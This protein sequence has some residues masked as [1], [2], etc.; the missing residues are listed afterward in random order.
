MAKQS[1]NSSNGRDTWQNT[2]RIKGPVQCKP[3]LHEPRYNQWVQGQG[4]E[5]EGVY[6][7]AVLKTLSESDYTISVNMPVD[8]HEKGTKGDRYHGDRIYEYA[9]LSFDIKFSLGMQR[10]FDFREGYPA[11]FHGQGMGVGLWPVTPGNH[12]S[13]SVENLQ[14]SDGTKLN[15]LLKY[16]PGGVRVSSTCGSYP[17][18][19]PGGVELPYPNET[20]F[21]D[22]KR[23][24]AKI[25]FLDNTSFRW[26][27][28]ESKKVISDGTTITLESLDGTSKTYTASPNPSPGS[29]EFNNS[30]TTQDLVISLRDAINSSTG[31]DGKLIAEKIDY[32]HVDIHYLRIYQKDVSRDEGNLGNTEILVS[33]NSITP[34]PSV[35][36]GNPLIPD[37][38]AN[39]VSGIGISENFLPS[40]RPFFGHKNPTGSFE[41]GELSDW[42]EDG[43]LTRWPTAPTD[44]YQGWRITGPWYTRLT[45][46]EH[47]PRTTGRMKSI[48]FNSYDFRHEMFPSWYHSEF[49]A[50][51]TTNPTIVIFGK[52]KSIHGQTNQ[53]G[54]PF[55]QNFAFRM[56]FIIQH[57]S[58][59]LGSAFRMGYDDF[60][61]GRPERVSSNRTI[62]RMP[63]LPVNLT[64]GHACYARMLSK[65]GFYGDESNLFKD[66]P[67]YGE[68]EIYR[69]FAPFYSTNNTMGSN[70]STA[71]P[72]RSFMSDHWG[73]DVSFPEQ[74]IIPASEL[75]IET[76][77]N[78]MV[79]TGH[80][81]PRWM[82]RVESEVVVIRNGE[83]VNPAF[84]DIYQ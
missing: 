2:I 84:Y 71:N 14:L 17:Y 13:V 54:S 62:I 69:S 32:Y 72:Y 58:A 65:G 41:G 56:D 3:G 6:N 51:M 82:K 19:T 36:Y 5:A 11:R 68:G 57:T 10:G 9:T 80:E 73:D 43:V 49:N 18:T 63:E 34:P 20:S 75:D 27:D 28:E 52:K 33:G 24:I 38:N 53:D 4:E 25:Y 48:Y 76:L 78:N 37:S 1:L 7:S 42:D 35:P 46:E 16:R 50:L 55:F 31:H 21:P 74:I 83:M 81:R 22:D 67:T 47:R 30:G 61:Q 66:G 29:T 44:S 70:S 15:S 60:Q 23:A 26:P 45:A 8:Y 77:E 79:G 12:V 39:F 40:G 59:E 64:P